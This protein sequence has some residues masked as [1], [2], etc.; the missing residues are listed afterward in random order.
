VTRRAHGFTLIELLVAVLI[1]AGIAGA[2]T[3]AVS[4]ALRARAGSE[5]RE[6]ASRRA[7]GAAARIALDA[8]NLVRAGDLFDA[9]VLL[10]SAGSGAL[11]RDEVL[12]FAHSARPARSASEQSEGAVYEIQYRL[13]PASTLRPSAAPGVLWRRIDPVPDEV[14]DGGGVAEPVV[15]GIVSLS[16]EAFDGEDWYEDWDSDRD[17]YPHALR[18]TVTAR[19]P[20]RNALATARRVVAIDR[21]PVPYTTTEQAAAGAGGAR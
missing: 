21:T 19:A 4:Q 8:H 5:A 10:V 9:R 3:V 14:T 16:I 1:V 18:I 17:G 7:D 12:L 2:S 11:P 20:E 13:E 6:E 15:E